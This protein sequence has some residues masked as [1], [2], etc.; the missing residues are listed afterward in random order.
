MPH[1]QT[2]EGYELSWADAKARAEAWYARHELRPAPLSHKPNPHRFELQHARALAR[3]LQDEVD[4]T[5]L[6]YATAD[7]TR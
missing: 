7:E 5:M 3:R 1:L 6:R 4:A 2:L